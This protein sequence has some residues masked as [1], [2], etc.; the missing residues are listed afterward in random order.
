MQITTLALIACLLLIAKTLISIVIVRKIY[1]FLS[2]KAADIS[3]EMISKI[4][5]LDLIALQS[6]SSQN[7]LYS[8]TTGVGTVALGILA[9][10]ILYLALLIPMVLGV[11]MMMELFS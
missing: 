11:L 4:L 10:T 9:T 7:V 8:L 6:Q 5:N 3:K 1:Y 2:N